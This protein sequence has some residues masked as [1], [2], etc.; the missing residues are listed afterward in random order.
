MSSMHR[1]LKR[2]QLYD[3]SMFQT[4]YFCKKVNPPLSATFGTRFFV[5][6]RY[7]IMYACGLHAI[8]IVRILYTHSRFCYEI[9][10]H[11]FDVY[12]QR[13]YF[14]SDSRSRFLTILK[15]LISIVSTNILH[16][17]ALQKV[18]KNLFQVPKHLLKDS[19]TFLDTSDNICENLELL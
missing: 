16:F 18:S 14:L 5:Y 11:D 9:S 19:E 10:R 13:N 15:R 6:A 3:P 1:S 4:Y 12:Y 17:K 8:N 2:Y 7:T